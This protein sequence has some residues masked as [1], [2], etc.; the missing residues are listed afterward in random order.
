MSQAIATRPARRHRLGRIT[1]NPFLRSVLALTGGAAAAQLLSLLAMPILARLYTPQDFGAFGVFVAVLGIAACLATLQ[2][3]NA[4]PLPRSPRA[5]ANLLAAALAVLLGMSALFTAALLAADA[6]YGDAAILLTLRPMLWLMPPSFLAIGLYLALLGWMLRLGQFRVMAGARVT[7]SAVVAAAQIGFGLLGASGIG[8][9]MGNALGWAASAVVLGVAAWRVRHAGLARISPAGMGRAMRRYRKFP[10]VSSFSAMLEMIQMQAPVLLIT[11]LYGVQVG[12][13]FLIANR[14]TLLPIN[15]LALSISQVM[16][17]A[18]AG[19]AR[20]PEVLAR[21]LPRVLAGLAAVGCVLAVVAAVG[22]PL[23]FALVFGPEWTE[24]GHFVRAMAPLLLAQFC[25]VP[26]NA[27]LLTRERQ[28]VLIASHGGRVALLL[29]TLPLC[30]WAGLAAVEMVLI[31]ALTQ[32]AAYLAAL[33]AIWRIGR[34]GVTT[35]AV[36]A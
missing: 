14:V 30:A 33:L 19:E 29:V 27:I 31:Y 17:R 3:E 15:M 4:I 7:Q 32:A 2:Y 13:L 10:M 6:L 12:G 36:P 11:M 5:G 18:M 20:S 23:A 16:I 35:R 21:V 25:V 34:A 24:A 8:L 1:A 28:G 22:A 9:A 26:L